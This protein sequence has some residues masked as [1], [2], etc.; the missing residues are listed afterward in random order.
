MGVRRL[1]RLRPDLVGPDRH[2]GGATEA[3]RVVVELRHRRLEALGSDIHA[4]LLR[5]AGI[6]HDGCRAV[7]H[8]GGIADQHIRDGVRRPIQLEVG[9]HGVLALG[10]SQGGLAVDDDG[11]ELVRRG[12]AQSTSVQVIVNDAD[13]EFSEWVGADDGT[14]VGIPVTSISGVEGRALLADMAKKTVTLAAV[15]VSHSDV[16]YDIARFSQGEIPADL[17]YAPKNL[18]KIDTTY[19]GQKE[20]LGEFR[21]DFLPGFGYSAGYPCERSAGWCAPSG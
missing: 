3:V 15:G 2:D 8:D 5:G 10:K 13:G 9:H 6:E 14:S 1:H 7:E 19:Y 21:S 16:V 4:H 12:V 18:A 20:E 17:H 11:L